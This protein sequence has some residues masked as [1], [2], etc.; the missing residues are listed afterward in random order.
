VLISLEIADLIST[1]RQAL[2]GHSNG[3][4]CLQF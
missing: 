4:A 3:A 1:R 2:K